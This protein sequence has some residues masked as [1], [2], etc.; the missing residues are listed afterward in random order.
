MLV[1]AA[2]YIEALARTYTLINSDF[3]NKL[4]SWALLSPSP[5]RLPAAATSDAL[6]TPS[7]SCF[8]SLVVFLPLAE[9]GKEVS[10]PLIAT[11][12]V[13]VGQ[14]S[15]S[16]PQLSQLEPR[17][18]PQHVHSFWRWEFEKPSQEATWKNAL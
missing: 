18:N 4:T 7:L 16:F 13:V 1:S 11:V 9:Q 15:S 6:V 5:L 12:V 3:G 14:N 17:S 8:L 10:P 2:A